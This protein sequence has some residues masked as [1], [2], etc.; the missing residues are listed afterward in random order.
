MLR[1]DDIMLPNMIVRK[2]Q[3]DHQKFNKFAAEEV[4]SDSDETEE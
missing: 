2:F 1:S 4:F 3:I